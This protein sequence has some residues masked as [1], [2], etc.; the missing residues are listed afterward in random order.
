MITILIGV[1]FGSMVAVYA[2]DAQQYYTNTYPDTAFDLTKILRGNWTIS[3]AIH[4]K[5][6]NHTVTNLGN[7]TIIHWDN[8]FVPPGQ[9]TWACFNTATGDSAPVIAAL[10][11]DAEGNYIGPAGPVGSSSGS[12]DTSG[13]VIIDVS[14][15]WVQWNDTAYPVEE[16]SSGPP[17]G[18][19]I[20][21]DVYYAFT[22]DQLPM[23]SLN[24]TL[25][26]IGSDINW[27]PLG[28]FTLNY[29][30][31][32]S[33]NLQQPKG[34]AVALLRFSV[35]GGGQS[36]TEIVQYRFSTKTIPSLT[37]YGLLV[38]VLLLLL[39]AIIVIRQRRR[40]AVRHQG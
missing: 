30:E 8:G 22:A 14:H 12:R 34:T 11:T 16:D 19:I 10:W 24:E 40:T 23:A 29:G 15:N 1:I 38:L 4:D 9:G 27:V 35:S 7:L 13:N 20:G 17:Y 36:A 28:G 32:Q 25:W 39:S 21:T 26:D 6:K 31:A 18:P 37:G 2:Y 3:G 5:F 33:Y